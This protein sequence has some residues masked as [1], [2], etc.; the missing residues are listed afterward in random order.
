MVYKSLSGLA[1]AYMKDV[2]KFVK[3]VNTWTWAVCDVGH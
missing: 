1:P 2:F 3:D